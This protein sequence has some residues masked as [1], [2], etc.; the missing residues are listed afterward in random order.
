VKSRETLN[1]VLGLGILAA[2]GAGL[3]LLIRWVVER[4]STLESQTSSAII[5]GAVAVLIA[6]MGHAF[7]VTWNRRRQIEEA[8][9]PAKT[10]LYEEFI[11]N[12][13]T[14]LNIGRQD[15]T[16][17]VTARK[18]AKFGETQSKITQKMILWGSDEVISTYQRWWRV[19]QRADVG[20]S[21]EELIVRFEDVLFAFRRDLG[22]KNK[23]L[24]RAHLLSLFI[25]DI[26]KLD[27]SKYQLKAA[28]GQRRKDSRQSKRSLPPETE[29][30]P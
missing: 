13:F 22:H 21:N 18:Q 15:T 4:A 26:E 12:W 2:A 10:E 29:P 24:D 6:A 28:K 20:S 7:Q 14:V 8:Q 11:D 25:N 5:A 23:G 19:A 16:Q 30:N 27:L 1:L 17:S 3:F 9:R